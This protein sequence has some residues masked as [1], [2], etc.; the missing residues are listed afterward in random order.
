MAGILKKIISATVLVAGGWLAGANQ[1]AIR[2]ISESVKVALGN[3]DKDV[4][5]VVVDIEVD[6]D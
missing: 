6:I 5:D 3:N 1:Q 4:D 2:K